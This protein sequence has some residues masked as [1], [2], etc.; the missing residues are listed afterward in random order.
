MQQISAEK[1]TPGT[2]RSRLVKS[3]TEARDKT[4]K[5]AELLEQFLTDINGKSEEE[6]V[7]SFGMMNSRW[8]M[9]TALDLQEQPLLNADEVRLLERVDKMI[10]DEKKVKC[11]F[12]GAIEHEEEICPV[13]KQGVVANKPEKAVKNQR[14]AGNAAFR[15]RKVNEKRQETFERML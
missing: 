12:C 6:T 2:K 14:R 13:M 15:M 10:C 4:I 3:L 8:I 11:G 5:Y 7:N 9:L 1:F